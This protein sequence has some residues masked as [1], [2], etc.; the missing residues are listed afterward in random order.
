MGDMVT[1]KCIAIVDVFL[2]L[3]GLA[4]IYEST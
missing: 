1:H 2:N 3:M 4:W